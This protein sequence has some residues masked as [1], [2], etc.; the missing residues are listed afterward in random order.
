MKREFLNGLGLEKEVVDKIMAEHGITL[1]TEKAKFSDYEDLKVQLKTANGT[2]DSFG[3]V[4]AMKADVIKYKADAQQAKL[5]ADK[6]IMEIETQSKVKEFTG[7]KQF[8]NSLTKEAIEAKLMAELEN[9]TSEGKSFDDIFKE[10]T[11]GQENLLVDTNRP[12][13]PVQTPLGGGTVQTKT[14]EN[15][16]RSAMGLPA[17]KE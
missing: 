11:Q 4:E 5:D 14:A 10:I 12:L 16:M 2:I 15:T 1:N 3:D 9:E 13:P 6:R 17:I 7:A 8:V